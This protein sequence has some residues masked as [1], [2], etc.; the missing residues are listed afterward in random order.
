MRYEIN[1][2]KQGQDWI[3]IEL[4]TQSLDFFMN[5]RYTIRN[6]HEIISTKTHTTSTSKLVIYE[7]K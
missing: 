1:V 5:S 3:F 6:L 7:V 2:Y 4:E